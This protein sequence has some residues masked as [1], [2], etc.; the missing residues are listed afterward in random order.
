M[1]RLFLKL[2][3][4]GLLAEGAFAQVNS[5]TQTVTLNATLS[6]AATPTSVNFTELRLVRR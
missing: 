4:L 3:A 6:I 2:I 5:N 1:L